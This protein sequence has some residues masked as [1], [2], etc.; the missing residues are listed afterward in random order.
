M[1]VPAEVGSRVETLKELRV[2]KKD[3]KNCM[4]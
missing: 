3:L 2:L 4:A 1:E